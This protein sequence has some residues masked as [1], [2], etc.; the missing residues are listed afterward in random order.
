M[1][2]GAWSGTVPEKIAWALE[3][4]Q[5]IKTGKANAQECGFWSPD[6]DFHIPVIRFT[7][8]GQTLAILPLIKNVPIEEIHYPPDN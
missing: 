8:L 6:A 3:H 1:G 2:V 5:I 4:K 7:G